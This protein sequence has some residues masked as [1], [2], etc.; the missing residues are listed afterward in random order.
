ML[1]S[2]NII[3]NVS[4]MDINRAHRTSGAR[5]LFTGLSIEV[6]TNA[7]IA[8][9]KFPVRAIFIADNT[10]ASGKQSKLYAIVK[11]RRRNRAKYKRSGSDETLKEG[12]QIGLGRFASLKRITSLRSS[13]VRAAIVYCTQSQLMA[14]R[15]TAGTNGFIRGGLYGATRYYT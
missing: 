8:V 7:F 4:K 15:G 1:P 14:I 10:S 3:E 9:I 12:T 6:R 13:T 2:P 5:Y 11:Q